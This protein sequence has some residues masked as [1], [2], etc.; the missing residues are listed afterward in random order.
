MIKLGLDELPQSGAGKT[1]TTA[2]PKFIPNEAVELKI[3][4]NI[5]LKVRVV[6]CVGY[7]VDGALGYEDE[8]GAPRMVSTPWYEEPIPFQEA[9]ELVLAGNFRSFYNRFCGNYRRQYH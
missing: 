5:K 4:D 8:Q 1:I 3:Q 6:D 2:E 9:A 7:T